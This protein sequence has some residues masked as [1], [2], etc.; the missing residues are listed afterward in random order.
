MICHKNAIPYGDH[1]NVIL[2]IAV[3]QED[4]LKNPWFLNLVYSSM[5][6]VGSNRPLLRKMVLLS[7]SSV[8]LILGVNT[9]A[10]PRGDPRFSGLWCRDQIFGEKHAKK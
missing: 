5:D 1:L 9:C 8:L 7:K 2:W 3:N 4:G 6:S 10:N